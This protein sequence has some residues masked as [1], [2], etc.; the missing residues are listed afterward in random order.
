MGSGI[1]LSTL[2]VQQ[3]ESQK[4]GEDA[5]EACH[6]PRYV[7]YLWNLDFLEFKPDYGASLT[8]VKLDMGSDANQGAGSEP[9]TRHEPDDESYDRGANWDFK[10]NLPVAQLYDVTTD[11]AA[12]FYNVYG[13]TQDNFSFGGPARTR[14][15][16]GIVNSDWFVMLAV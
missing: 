2:H 4:N 8:Q 12:P 5:N 6:R 13:G 11:N 14:S 15:A 3:T 16:S 10:S 1:R 7:A 9:S